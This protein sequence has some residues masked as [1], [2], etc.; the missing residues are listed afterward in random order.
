MGFILATFSLSVPAPETNKSVTGC[1]KIFYIYIDALS[2]EN[3]CSS[4]AKELVELKKSLECGIVS[5]IW[6]STKNVVDSRKKKPSTTDSLKLTRPGA[7]LK[8]RLML[9]WIK[10][11]NRF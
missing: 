7:F 4:D 2:V 3:G 8:K 11:E 10:K 9:F 1:E 6:F 5:L